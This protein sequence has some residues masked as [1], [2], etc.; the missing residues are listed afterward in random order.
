MVHPTFR[1]LPAQPVFC[2]TVPLHAAPIQ[3]APLQAV[4]LET[5]RR[6]VLLAGLA[7]PAL[8]HAQMP[9]V[10]LLVNGTPGSVSDAF[11]RALA[12]PLRERLRRPVIIDN[13]SGAGGFAS[14]LGGRGQP[15]DGSVLLH[16]PIGVA[17]LAPLV[18]RRPPLDP[19]A[20]L[21]PI[22]HLTDS[23]F[24]LAVRP[25][26]PG[27]GSL[28]GWLA[29]MRA[30]G[31]GEVAVNSATGLPRFA[32]H[33]L[34]ALHGVAL[35]PVIYR[36]S[37]AMLPD[38]EAG[39]VPAGLTISGE[40]LEHHR[41]GRL[42]LL[43]VSLAEGRWPEAPEVPRFNEQG[44]ADFVASAWNGLFGP[45]GLTSGRA[46]ELAMTV[47]EALRLPA[48]IARARSLGLEPTGGTPDALRARIAADRARWAPVIA[49]SG[50]RADE[51]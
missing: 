45:A 14:A 13:R 15:A 23:P 41:A 21:V 31:G 25:D 12:E 42:R 32:V 8:A 17:A 48:A 9:P 43:A 22:V 5:A 11:V 49:A 19:D 6:A 24:G 16:V 10:R 38:L 46:A 18:F 3:S 35:T 51:P 40:F 39:H 44:V 37:G 33:L 27:G 2:Q 7:V 4:P 28:A 26:A 29:A 47:T 50:F 1:P 36:S 30:A 34:A 20:E